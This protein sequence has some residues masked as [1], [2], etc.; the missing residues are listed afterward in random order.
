MTEYKYRVVIRR[1]RDWVI[2]KRI[3]AQCLDEVRELYP[4]YKYDIEWE[5][6]NK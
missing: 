6:F 4:S 3:S 2:V 5:Y 1:K